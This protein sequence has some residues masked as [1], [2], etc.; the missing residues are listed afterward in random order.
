MMKTLTGVLFA[1]G[2][3]RRMGMDKAT[4]LLNGEPLWRRQIHLLR[5]LSPARIIVSARSKPVWCPPE[6]EL[7]LDDLPSRG[8]VSGLAATLKSIQ[9]THLLALAVD[10]PQMT[11]AHLEKLWLLARMGIGIVPQQD[12]LVEPLSAIY[13]AEAASAVERALATEDFSLHGVIRILAARGQMRFY[14]IRRCEGVLYRNA[15]TKEEWLK[16]SR[17]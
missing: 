16:T 2:E 5:A 6:I 11:S 10:L 3:S 7:V 14:P 13:P 12:G 17:E 1:G 9:T 15:N 4:L 8:P